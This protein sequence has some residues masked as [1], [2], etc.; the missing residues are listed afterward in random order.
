MLS[1]MIYSGIYI[2][3]CFSCLTWGSIDTT[4]YRTY[5][6]ITDVCTAV[7]YCLIDWVH[8][9][10]HMYIRRAPYLNLCTE[11]RL[12]AGMVNV[13]EQ[14]QRRGHLV[15]N[16]LRRWL[17]PRHVV[18]QLDR[19]RYYYA[20]SVRQQIRRAAVRPGFQFSDT[21]TNKQKQSNQ[22]TISVDV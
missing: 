20:F 17:H 11:P 1:C 10:V 4:G 7:L 9:V 19:L 18:F 21:N 16:R 13:L 5:G 8:R 12:V 2:C 3:A 6:I 15:V 14:V 22:S